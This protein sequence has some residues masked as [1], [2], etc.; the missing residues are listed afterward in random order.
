VLKDPLLTASTNV[1]VINRIT[2][3]G[4]NPTN[5]ERAVFE[6]SIKVL[7]VTHDP[8]HFDSILDSELATGPHFPA[9][10]R[11]TPW[12]NLA[13]TCDK[14]DLLEVDEAAKLGEILECLCRL[15]SGEFVTEISM[16][17][18]V[19]CL[20]DT[21]CLSTIDDLEVGRV[22]TSDSTTKGDLLVEAE[23]NAGGDIRKVWQTI[24]AAV[25][26]GPDGLHL[27]Y[28]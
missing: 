27:G 17:D 21:L 6:T 18:D 7:D 13:E 1:L 9:S 3:L 14:D 8:G 19:D 16:R 11:T 25:R 20:Q 10:T 2:R 5:I 22:V 4:I 12:A 28:T 23:T 24:H 15:E 26:T